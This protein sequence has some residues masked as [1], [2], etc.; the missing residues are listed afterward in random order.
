MVEKPSLIISSVRDQT[1]DHL[2]GIATLLVIFT[3]SIVFY[4]SN[5]FAFFLWDAV[6]F[7]VPLYVFSS[8]TLYFRKQKHLPIDF[9]RYLLKRSVR[10]LKPWYAFLLVYFGLFAFLGKPFSFVFMRDSFLLIGGVD[11]GW[12]VLLFMMI[13]CVLPFFLFLRRRSPTLFYL[14]VTVSFLSSIILLFYIPPINYKW[15]LWLPWSVVI[16]YAAIFPYLK[17][18][19]QFTLIVLVTTAIL[20]YTLLRLFNRPLALFSNKYPP[21]SF[22]LF[23]GMSLVMILYQGSQHNLFRFRPIHQLLSY[24]GEHSYELFFIHYLILRVFEYKKL[25]HS[26]SWP[27]LFG[28][29]LILSLIFDHMLHRLTAAFSR[30]K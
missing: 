30:S 13:T 2:K 26:T 16:G 24:T 4:T 20:S 25:I 9:A 23:Y 27:F 8:V 7:A 1:I 14:F 3:H 29:V 6:H 5:S 18:K 21:N 17:K 28:L 22:Y 10:L 11:I 19:W 12:L 15:Y